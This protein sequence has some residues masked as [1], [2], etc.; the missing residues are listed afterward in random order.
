[1]FFLLVQFVTSRLISLYPNPA[2]KTLLILFSWAVVLVAIM[3]ASQN[4]CGMIGN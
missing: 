3:S 2:L 4:L 1:M